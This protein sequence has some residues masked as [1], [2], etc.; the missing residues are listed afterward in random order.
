LEEAQ[1]KTSS[2]R[3]SATRLTAERFI[4]SREGGTQSV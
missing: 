1:V 2:S 4:I 3:S